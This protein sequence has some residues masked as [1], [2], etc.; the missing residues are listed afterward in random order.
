MFNF[1]EDDLRTNLIFTRSI[2]NKLFKFVQNH[3][4]NVILFD[5]NEVDVDELKYNPNWNVTMIQDH[6]HPKHEPSVPQII[7]NPLG[8]CTTL[9]GEIIM[10]IYTKDSHYGIE[11]DE[12]LNSNQLKFIYGPIVFD[13]KNFKKNLK[14]KV[15]VDD[16]LKVYNFIKNHTE[17]DP[18]EAKFIGNQVENVVKPKSKEMTMQ[19][20]VMRDF[21]AFEYV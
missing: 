21:K 11:I 17:I 12:Y 20:H 9:V 13:T 8:S 6:H 15:W 19:H 1:S 18:V 4:I 7:K 2:K 10:D 16:D 5:H 14:N 3:K